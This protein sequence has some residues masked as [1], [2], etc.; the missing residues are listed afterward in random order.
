MNR[1]VTSNSGVIIRPLMGLKASVVQSTN[2]SHRCQQGQI[3]NE[4]HGTVTLFDGVRQSIIPK[5][6]A[7]FELTLPNGH[8]IC[9]EGKA[10][11]GHPAERIRRAKRKQ[12]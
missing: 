3:I 2:P 9:V 4:T 12:W 10:L 6:V 5:D 8:T 7:V 1:G 11:V